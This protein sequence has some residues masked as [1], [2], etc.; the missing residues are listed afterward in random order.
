[1][2]DLRQM[3]RVAGIGVFSSAGRKRR[4]ICAGGK[5]IAG[6]NDL[7]SQFPEIAAQWHPEKNGMLTPQQVTPYSNRKVWWRCDLGHDY[8]TLISA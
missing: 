5:V 3:A 8:Q 7:A 1:M 4:P 2:V 6:E